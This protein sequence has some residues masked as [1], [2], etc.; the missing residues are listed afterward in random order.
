MHGFGLKLFDTGVPVG[1]EGCG[2]RVLVVVIIL[3]RPGGLDKR[4]GMR[5]KERSWTS[6]LGELNKQQEEE[7]TTAGSAVQSRGKR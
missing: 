7:L 4:V 3:G 6:S 1:F 2:D 5:C